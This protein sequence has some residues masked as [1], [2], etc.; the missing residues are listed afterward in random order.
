MTRIETNKILTSKNTN[1]GFTYSN[2][3]EIYI[4]NKSLKG[5]D[6]TYVIEDGL[7]CPPACNVENKITLF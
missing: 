5:V 2:G 3:N 6:E 7:K 4:E 1:S